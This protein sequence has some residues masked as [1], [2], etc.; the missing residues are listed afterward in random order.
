[1]LLRDNVRGT[2]AGSPRARTLGHA[3]KIRLRLVIREFVPGSGVALD[4]EIDRAG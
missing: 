1:M 3:F 4:E 2:S